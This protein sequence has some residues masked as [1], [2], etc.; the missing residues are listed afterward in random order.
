MA[1]FA[2]LFSPLKESFYS[3]ERE[4]GCIKSSDCDDIWRRSRDDD[5]REEE[6]GWAERFVGFDRE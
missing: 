1:N 4:Q 5:E 6:E 2:A 3:I